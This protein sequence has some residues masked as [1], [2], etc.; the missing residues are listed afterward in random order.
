MQGLR[1]APFVI[2]EGAELVE[3]AAL[4]TP[5][6]DLA[7]HQHRRRLRVAHAAPVAAEICLRDSTPSI[8]TFH[9]SNTAA[10]QRMISSLGT[11]CRASMAGRS[12]LLTFSRDK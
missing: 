7:V 10:T 8:V 1:M 11:G 2:V 9:N 6:H 3:A 5:A 12:C 4:L